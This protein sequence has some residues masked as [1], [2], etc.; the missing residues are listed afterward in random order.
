MALQLSFYHSAQT[1]AP[2]RP[3]FLGENA[4]RS[5]SGVADRAACARTSSA[6][7]LVREKHRLHLSDL[8]LPVF[9][10]DGTARARPVAFDAR[11]CSAR[12]S[13]G[14]LPV[15]EASRLACR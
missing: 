9:M 1:L 15:A 8:I 2:A 6:A 7:P 10:L 14:L 11:A 12:A 4:T 5:V 13:I 3:A